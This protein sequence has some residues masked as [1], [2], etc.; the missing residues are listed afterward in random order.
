MTISEKVRVRHKCRKQGVLVL[1]RAEHVAYR[2]AA[3]IYNALCDWV[4]TTYKAQMRLTTSN[5]LRLLAFRT[6]SLRYK[7]PYAELFGL[8]IP[9]L[10]EMFVLNP[11]SAMGVGAPFLVCRRSEAILE[12]AILEKYPQFEHLD[13]WRE[14]EKE[15]QLAVEHAIA[16]GGLQEKDN[17]LNVWDD[18]YVERYLAS[19]RAKR[20]ERAKE[21]NSK[22]RR[23]RKYRNS[24]WI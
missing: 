4:L 24:P 5:Q 2:F 20:E 13:A 16:L 8:L 1:S 14:R 21:E 22:W 6:W 17:Q 18:N 19:V 11:K 7:L 12:K 9:K 3:E 23:V 15:R 10:R